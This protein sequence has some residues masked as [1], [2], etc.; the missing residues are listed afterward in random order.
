[1]YNR[2]PPPHTRMHLSFVKGKLYLV[3]N[4]NLD[5]VNRDE[6]V[7][8][9]YSYCCHVLLY[10]IYSTELNGMLRKQRGK[11]KSI[12]RREIYNNYISVVRVL[13][14][15]NSRMPSNT[16]LPLSYM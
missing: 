4:I 7:M 13:E 5:Y 14:F 3:V 16:V 2:T 10:L 1:M 12:A 6:S 11:K 15:S 8:H 9:I